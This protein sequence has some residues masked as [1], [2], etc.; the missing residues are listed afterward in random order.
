MKIKISKLS[1]LNAKHDKIPHSSFK[2]QN[3]QKSHVHICP[4]LPKVNLKRKDASKMKAVCFPWFCGCFI[5]S[6][7]KGK[8]GQSLES[9]SFQSVLGKKMGKADKVGKAICV[10]HH[11]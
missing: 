5:S 8:V 4:S 7:W 6:W 9:V 3:R 10:L 11:L 1:I 2:K